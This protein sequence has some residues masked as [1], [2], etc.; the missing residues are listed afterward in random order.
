MGKKD[1]ICRGENFGAE[2]SIS[3]RLQIIN[4]LK[5]LRFVKKNCIV[6]FNNFDFKFDSLNVIVNLINKGAASFIVFKISKTDHG[7]IAAKEMGL[8][9]Y[10]INKSNN[11]ILN[12]KDKI[13]TLKENQIYLGKKR[14]NN[15]KIKLDKLNTKHE[16]K[17]NIGFPSNKNYSKIF[18]ACSG[19]GF[20][21]IEFLLSKILNN[22]HPHKYI[23][24]IGNKNF[25]NE[26][27]DQIR[28]ALKVL[29]KQKK[30]FWIRT[31]D[32][33]VEQLIKME[34]GKN[35]ET[36]EKIS[37]T[38]Y[39][40]IRRSNK[41]KNILTPLLMAIKKLDSE[42]FKNIGIFPPMVNNIL[43][44]KKWVNI[45]KEHKLSNI[46]KGLMVE[47]PRAAI[48][49][50]EFLENIDFIIF[51]TN[52][53]TSF[54]LAVDRNNLNIRHMFDE[55]D[56]V[57]I[58]VISDVIKKCK[59]KNVKTFLSGPLTENKST[60]KKLL[61][62]GLTGVTINPDISTINKVKK[63]IFEIEKKL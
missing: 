10:Q 39:R 37:S 9:F 45:L 4:N 18:N 55:N 17:I 53:L 48:M 29:K 59:S 63:I 7:C 35:Y 26:I 40:G 27:A 5:E 1:I 43:E 38:G 16:I 47:T 60:L 51:G 20:S 13:I 33:S 22:I 3:G 14:L 58:K 34:F 49:I 32:F 2:K 56:P 62:V 8:N 36:E 52:D 54:L 46:K 15:K 44:Y 12:Y 31:D 30:E 42:G 24:F 57:V 41:E 50:E 25:S 21:R 6:L 19:V 61:S 11:K 28:P 23:E